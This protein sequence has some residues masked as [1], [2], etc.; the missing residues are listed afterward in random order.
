LVAKGVDAAIALDQNLFGRVEDM[1]QLAAGHL[2]DRSND[3]QLGGLGGRRLVEPGRRLGGE[4]SARLVALEG[5][6]R[7]DDAV[8]VLVRRVAREFVFRALPGRPS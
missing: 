8:E 5:A 2:Y 6:D 7:R 3:G 4:A 1:G